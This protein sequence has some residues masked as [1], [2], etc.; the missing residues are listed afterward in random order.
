MGVYPI[1][2]CKSD[3]NILKAQ[4]LLLRTPPCTLSSMLYKQKRTGNIC[5]YVR[6]LTL[7]EKHA[8]DTAFPLRSSQFIKG[9]KI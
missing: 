2:S 6:C 7:L 3:N 5:L 1:A 8:T 9:H 4:Q